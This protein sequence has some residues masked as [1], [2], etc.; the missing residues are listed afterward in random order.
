MILE[1]APFLRLF[2]GI[3]GH[4]SVL[5]MGVDFQSPLSLGEEL[6]AFG[7]SRLPSS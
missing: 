3:D 5:R 6:S 7:K 1:H 4:E 2:F